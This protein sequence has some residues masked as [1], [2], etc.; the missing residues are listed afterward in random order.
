[1]QELLRL[2][3]EDKLND[4]QKLWFRESR[5]PEELYD[6]EADPYNINN[7]ADDPAYADDMERMRL[8]MD[9]WRLASRDMGDISEYAM[10]EMAWPGG[11]QPA[12]ARPHFVPN[13]EGNRNS[14]LA[15]QGGQYTHP[16]TVSLYCATQGASIAYS[17]DK[18]EEPNWKLY[19]GPIRLSQG[20]TAIRSKAIRYG[21]KH[22]EEVTAVFEVQ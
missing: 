15:D 21:F 8:A 11:E 1:M 10:K 17:M 16:M 5:P 20:T 4:V 2:H 3:A 6:C 7:L 9:A 12:T 19:T 22:S 13:T 18:G 14:E